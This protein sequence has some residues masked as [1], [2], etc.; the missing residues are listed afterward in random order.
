MARRNATVSLGAEDQVVVEPEEISAQLE[1]ESPVAIE[2]EE[3][4]CDAQVWLSSVL[5]V[6]PGHEQ[7]GFLSYVKN[8]SL[9]YCKP[10]VWQQHFISWKYSPA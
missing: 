1:P 5:P 2:E 6:L 9:T 7:H 4:I 10:S 8:L 3:S